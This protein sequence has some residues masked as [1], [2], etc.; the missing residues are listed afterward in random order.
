MITRK[1]FDLPCA[2]KALEWF[3]A[4]PT[5][6]DRAHSVVNSICLLQL[7]FRFCFTTFDYKTALTAFVLYFLGAWICFFRL[8][9]HVTKQFFRF[10]FVVLFDILVPMENIH[11]GCALSYL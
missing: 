5:V 11:F 6:E 1:Y 3:E 4:L 2:L 10:H 9:F 7:E 8:S